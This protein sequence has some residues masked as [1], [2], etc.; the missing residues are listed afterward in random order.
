MGQNISQIDNIANGGE[1]TLIKWPDSI[2]LTLHWRYKNIVF[3]DF[4]CKGHPLNTQFYGRSI[5]IE[6][7]FLQGEHDDLRLPFF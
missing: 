6:I 7:A 5:L 3:L 2:L 4:A 1:L